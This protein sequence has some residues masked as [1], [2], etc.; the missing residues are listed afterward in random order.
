[1]AMPI[2]VLLYADRRY[3]APDS[4]RQSVEGSGRAVLTR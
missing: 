1:M 3:G 2:L 4:A